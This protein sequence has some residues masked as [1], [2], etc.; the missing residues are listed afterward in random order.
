MTLSD[1]EHFK[2][3]L[4]EREQNLTAWL[5]SSGSPNGEDVQKAQALLMDIRQAL[6]RVENQTFGACQGSAPAGICKGEV[7]LYRLEVQPVTEVCL[8]CI[9]KEEQ[10]RLEEELFLASKIHRA[11]LPQSIER[12]EGY[13]VGVKA[14]AAR[15]VGGDYYDFLPSANGGRLR[16][17]I[18][19]TMG[20]GIPAGLLMSHVQGALKIL[21]ED[22]ESPRLLISRLNQW[23]CRNVPVTKFVS[24]SCLALDSR[25]GRDSQITYTN[26]GH[27]PPILVRNDGKVE[28]L[29]PTG[30]VLGV[31]EGFTYE[32]HTLSL[33]PGDLLVLYTD[34]VT[35]AENYHGGMFGEERLIEFAQ[36]RRTDPLDK[37]LDDL[38]GEVQFF[39]EKPEMDDDFTVIALRKTAS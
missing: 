28:R 7:E 32:E 29:E 26:A 5:D 30:G 36:T 18:A 33:S 16:V 19:D 2:N 35:E 38:L 39:S 31:H 11:L 23:L 6:G 3:L 8:G 24:L 17:V 15:S 21:S 9:T 34:G 4:I 13:D 1:L 37:F 20:K 22:I 27:C 25:A 10:A 14:L 12:I